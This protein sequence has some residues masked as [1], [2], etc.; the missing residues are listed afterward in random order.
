MTVLI[1]QRAADSITDGEFDL[2][3]S[4]VESG[5]VIDELI[6]LTDDNCGTTCDSACNSCP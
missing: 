6:R 2:D 1:D 5:P 3:I 4:I